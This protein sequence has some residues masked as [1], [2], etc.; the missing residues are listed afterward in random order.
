MHLCIMLMCHF[1]A[2]VDNQ[3]EMGASLWRLPPEDIESQLNASNVAMEKICDLNH[4]KEQSMKWYHLQYNTNIST[5]IRVI[6]L[7][8]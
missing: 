7:L 5:Y 4:D 3:V 6:I 1:H 2:V 8:S